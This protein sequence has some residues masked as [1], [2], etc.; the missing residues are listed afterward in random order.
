M[1]D[2]LYKRLPEALENDFID[3]YGLDKD[4]IVKKVYQEPNANVY[5]ASFMPFLSK[6]KEHPH[7]KQMMINGFVE[8]IEIHVKCFE[9]YA[10]SEVNFVGSISYLFQEHLESAAEKTEINL[11]HIIRKPI[12]ALV[13]YHIKY[14]LNKDFA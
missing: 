2:F 8:F 9:E 1:V 3:D 11:G 10:Q 5:I 4:E 14:I 13:D 12:D 7:I 6:H